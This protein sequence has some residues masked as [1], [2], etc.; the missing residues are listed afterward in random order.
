[1]RET[2]LKVFLMPGT[3]VED[4]AKCSKEGFVGKLLNP[5]KLL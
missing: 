3:D 4:R 1:M 2:A 5:H